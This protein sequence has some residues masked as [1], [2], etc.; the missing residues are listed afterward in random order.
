MSRVIFLDIDLSRMKMFRSLTESRAHKFEKQVPYIFLGKCKHVF[1][2][3]L[4]LVLIVL[5]MLFK[6]ILLVCCKAILREYF[7][8]L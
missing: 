7:K 1:V 4:R 2:L 6:N 5:I 8:K 3:F